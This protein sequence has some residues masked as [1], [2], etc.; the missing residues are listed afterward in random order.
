MGLR[1]T[2]Y[3]LHTAMPALVR[4]GGLTSR[5]SKDKEMAKAARE[6][7]WQQRRSAAARK[8]QGKRTRKQLRE[9]GIKLTE[10]EKCRW[11]S[12]WRCRSNKL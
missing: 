8:S 2:V 1:P 3:H 10:L 5:R 12:T 11:N 9:L 7:T 4:S 6:I